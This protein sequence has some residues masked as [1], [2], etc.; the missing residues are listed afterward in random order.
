MKRFLAFAAA[1][2]VMLS[3]AAGAAGFD[4]AVILGD[5]IA[6]GYGLDGYVAG[7]NYSAAESFGNRLAADCG[8]CVNLAVDGRTTAQ[9]LE[10]LDTAE[11]S[12]AVSGAD[13]VIV[14]IGGNDFLQPMLTA[15]Q[16]AM[17]TNPDITNIIQGG[18]TADIDLEAVSKQISQSVLQA[19]EAVDTAKSGKNISGILTK[20]HALNPAAEVKL[21][22]VYN[23]F[24]DVENFYFDALNDNY[25][26]VQAFSYASIFGSLS[27]IAETKLAQLNYEI[28]NAANSSGADIVDVY[29]AFKGHAEEYTNISY[30]DV[31]P[32]KD[33]HAVIYSLITE[34]AGSVQTSAPAKNI[35]STGA[36]S[37]AAAIGAVLLA[38]AAVIALRKKRA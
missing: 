27:D 38:S 6:S 32:N 8:E 35:P 17:F 19:A 21:L 25:A 26:A 30:Y 22:T 2:A 16:M 15:A 5:S 9:L 1:A 23:P 20:I 34:Q 11:M 14:S 31:H 10:A 12:E 37:A 29:S 13:C 3:T 36:E 7:D 33:G 28:V 24:E 4:K 18:D